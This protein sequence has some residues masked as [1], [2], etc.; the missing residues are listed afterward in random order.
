MAYY[1]A[2]KSKKSLWTEEEHQIFLETVRTDGRDYDILGQKI[3]TKDYAQLKNHV[4]LFL[5][6]SE[7]QPHLIEDDEWDVVEI[8]K[9][10][11]NVPFK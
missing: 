1:E 9:D 10:M 2:R 7:K 6:K 11:R 4:S 5:K 8:L 3:P